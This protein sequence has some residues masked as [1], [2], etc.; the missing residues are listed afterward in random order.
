M[1]NI[2]ENQNNTNNIDIKYRTIVQVLE[3]EN[4]VSREKKSPYI[5]ILAR[6]D[7]GIQRMMLFGQKRI[8]ACKKFNNKEIKVSD[9]LLV[10]GTRKKDTNAYFLDSIN[11]LDNPFVVK[12]S[13]LEKKEEKI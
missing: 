6:D 4:K 5:S 13:D 2:R 10:D 8:D 1:T 11:I 7:T 3:V 12:V 9:I